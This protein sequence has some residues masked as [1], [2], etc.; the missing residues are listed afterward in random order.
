MKSIS[1]DYPG[2]KFYENNSYIIQNSFFFLLRKKKT[3]WVL[4]LKLDYL[5]LMNKNCYI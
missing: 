5:L 4:L 2:K 1:Y 3:L